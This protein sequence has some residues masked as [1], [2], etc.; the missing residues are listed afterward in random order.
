MA[1]STEGTKYDFLEISNPVNLLVR[2]EREEVNLEDC[3]SLA[4]LQAM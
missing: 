4:R 3:K 2:G 1:G